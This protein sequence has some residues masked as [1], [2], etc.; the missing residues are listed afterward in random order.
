[1]LAFVGIPVYLFVMCICTGEVFLKL[2]GKG[3]GKNAGKN[4][5]AGYVI[6]AGLFHIISTPFMYYELSF[7]PLVYICIAYS[8]VIIAAY[9]ILKIKEE[10]TLFERVRLP[11]KNA[12][13]K[14]KVWLG[15]SIVFIIA[16]QIFY[17][18]YYQHT[19]IDDSYYLAQIN[20]IIHTIGAG[21][22]AEF[23]A[24][25]SNYDKVIIMTD[26]DVDGGHIRI[27]M[28]T[29]LY[30]YLKP[31]IEGGFVY[32]AQPPLYLLKHG[33]EE[34]YLYSDEELDDLR[35][36]LGE[37]AKY[38]IQRYK[39]LGEMNADQ[40]WETTMDP[41]HRILNRIEL[42]EAMEADMIFDVLMGE[43]VEPR[44]EFIQENA[45]YVTDLDI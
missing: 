39:G 14:D 17:V 24:S 1:M 6:C 27:L 29:F 34:H 12:I 2:F 30:R 23:D 11:E 43:K 18:V 26:A 31:L 35:T 19:D 33:K 7:S 41:E 38:S 40:L 20:T 22:G 3:E 9:I 28:L 13:Q 5:I 15:L 4:I 36:K 44:R 32:A 10:K 21:L 8:V 25:E 42:D 37:G 16:F 45:K